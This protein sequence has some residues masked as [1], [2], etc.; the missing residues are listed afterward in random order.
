ML[1]SRHVFLM[2][3]LGR[4]GCSYQSRLSKIM[5][6]SE[7]QKSI[8]FSS[9]ITVLTFVSRNRYPYPLPTSRATTLPIFHAISKRNLRSDAECQRRSAP[10]LDKRIE[11]HRRKCIA[12]QGNSIVT[13]PL[14]APRVITSRQKG[15]SDRQGQ[16]RVQTQGSIARGGIAYLEF[17][18]C[19]AR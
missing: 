15:G 6:A 16:E 10:M 7:T 11:I 4:R 2:L 13:S 17:A 1:T 3:T 9:N 5:E 19:A 8:Q 18:G 12:L 14:S